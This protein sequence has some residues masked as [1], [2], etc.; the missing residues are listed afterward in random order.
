MVGVPGD[1]PLRTDDNGHPVN[2]MFADVPQDEPEVEA[3]PG[4]EGEV[5]AFNLFAYLS[6]SR[7]DLEPV[8]RQRCARTAST[9]R[10]P[11]STSCRSSTATTASSGSSSCPTRST[12]TSRTATPARARAKVVMKAGDVAAMP[13]DIRHQG[14]S[15]K[16]SMLL[17]WENGVARRCPTLIARPGKA[18]DQTAGRVL[19]GS[20]RRRPCRRSCSSA[21]SSSTRSTA[22]PSRSA[23]RTTARVLAEVAEARRGRRRPGRRGRGRAPSRP[24]RATPAAERGRLLLRLADAIEAARRRAGPAGVARHRPPDPGHPRPRRAPHR[25]HLP[26]LRRHGRQAPGLGDPGR[27]RVPQL[28]DAAS[29]SASSARSCRGTSRSCSP[30]GRWARRWPPATPSC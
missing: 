15:P 26:L 21:A 19:T 25:G 3:E 6:R 23:T 10:R 5:A 8:G 16:R 27:R 4:F 9:A 7:R 1:E 11:R 20:D 24:G 29:R 22:A 18:A 13:A 28:R 30:A 12:G 17:V 14:Y 2:R